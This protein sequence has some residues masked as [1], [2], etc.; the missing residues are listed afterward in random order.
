MEQTFGYLW[1]YKTNVAA[2]IQF[3]T[4]TVLKKTDNLT[5]RSC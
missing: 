3:N 4:S 2:K 5:K 1:N